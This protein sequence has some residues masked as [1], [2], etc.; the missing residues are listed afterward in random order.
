M[1]ENIRSICDV[2]KS[3]KKNRKR[4]GY[5]GEK[6]IGFK[7]V[8]M[9]SSEPQIFSNGYSFKFKEISPEEQLGFIVPYWILN[10]M[11]LSIKI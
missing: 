11:I 9:I 3:T 6:G 2:G 1:E 7:S 10:L 8:F 5:I 4:E